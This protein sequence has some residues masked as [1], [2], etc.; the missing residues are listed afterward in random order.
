[1]PGHLH[2]AT[3]R[4]L[5]LFVMSKVCLVWVNWEIWKGTNI[6]LM[7]EWG[8]FTNFQ[9]M[10]QSSANKHV[11]NMLIWNIQSQ[12]TTIIFNTHIALQMAHICLWLPTACH[13]SAAKHRI[14]TLFCCFDGLATWYAIFN[15]FCG[16]IHTSNLNYHLYCS[17][18][19][20]PSPFTKLNM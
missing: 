5:C 15:L 9:K 1:M 17:T 19:M 2:M 16:I 12:S 6:Y 20:S 11:A 3:G 8:A 4:D 14:T 13:H 10:H 7:A 18:H